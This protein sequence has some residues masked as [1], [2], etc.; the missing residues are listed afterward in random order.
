M[1][2]LCVCLSYIGLKILK[3]CS[4]FNEKLKPL[5]DWFLTGLGLHAKPANEYKRDVFV[6]SVEFWSLVAYQVK[7]GMS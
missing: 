5:T 7:D 4:F 3:K 2:Q 6:A 1:L